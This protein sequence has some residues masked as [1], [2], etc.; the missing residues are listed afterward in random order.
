MPWLTDLPWIFVDGGSLLLD[1]LTHGSTKI[2]YSVSRSMNLEQHVQ[3]DI[4]DKRASQVNHILFNST[5]KLQTKG[6][7]N[8]RKDCDIPQKTVYH[9][10][11]R[12]SPF[13]HYDN[14][15]SLN[16]TLNL[17]CALR[18]LSRTKKNHISLPSELP[19]LIFLQAVV[20]WWV[21][22]GLS[23]TPRHSLQLCVQQFF[24][25]LARTCLS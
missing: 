14:K 16:Y 9:I 18:T 7:M 24:L 8:K 22:G 11:F 4:P 21:V 3:P 6:N 15:Q 2:N 25:Q 17:E 23:S 19:T 10:W 12:I 20:P 5:L 1:L 13:S